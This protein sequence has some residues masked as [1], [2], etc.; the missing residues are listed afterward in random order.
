VDDAHDRVAEL[1]DLAVVDGLEP[2]ATFAERWRQ[3]LAP[4]SSTSRRAPER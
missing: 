3:Y 4:V 1:D 2:N